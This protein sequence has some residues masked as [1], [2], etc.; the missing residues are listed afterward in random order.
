ML[1]FITKI[2]IALLIL[3]I[4]VE[5]S[6]Q[7]HWA[8]QARNLGPSRT[9]RG[10]VSMMVVYVSTPRYRWSEREIQSTF[11]QIWEAAYAM[12]SEARRYGVRLNMSNWKY[13]TVSMPM[14]HSSNDL[15]WYWY[16]MHN[17]FR[18]ENMQAY[19]NAMRRI[20]NADDTPI[21]FMLKR[22]ND[23]GNVIGRTHVVMAYA[24]NWNE[25]FSFLFCGQGFYGG[26]LFHEL[27]HQ[28]G[29][30]DFYDYQNEGVQNI[31]RQIFG[32]T[33]MIDNEYVV[34]SLTAYLIG[35]I[36]YLPQDA[37][38]FLYYTANRR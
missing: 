11:N 1:K 15:S 30:M 28:Y 36:N 12:E 33:C 23:P 9:L 10:K 13:Y 35:W 27:M 5:V 4:T 24:G 32:R 21:I 3:T 6:A 22:P 38:A 2:F 16:L 29:A 19:H 7:N 18:V 26:Y 25:E 20:E 8:L 31:A 37:Q 34:D 17:F 14:E